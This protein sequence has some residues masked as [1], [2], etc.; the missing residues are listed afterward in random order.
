M[1][2]GTEEI[3]AALLT[4]GRAMTQSK[5]HGTLCKR[6]GVDLDRSG[7]ALLYK[8]YADGDDIH[9][10]VLA[11]RLDIDA[12]AVTRKVQQLERAGLLTR[13]RDAR[14]ARAL[15]ITLTSEGRDEVERLLAA[16]RDWLDDRLATWTDAERLEFSRL[17]T[18]FAETLVEG[19]GELGD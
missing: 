1:T 4:V 12:P 2:Q 18:R 6:A 15:R 3:A 19:S 14:D 11:E 10:A 13:A 9:L 8:L 5:A 7:A 17:L 16:R